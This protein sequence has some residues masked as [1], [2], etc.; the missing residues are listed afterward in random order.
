MSVIA[1]FS[2]LN[3]ID[4]AHKP[5]W[6]AVGDNCCCYCEDD[7][8]AIN[9]VAGTIP[10]GLFRS[11]RYGGGIYM[12]VGNNVAAISTDGKVFSSIAIPPGNWS[13]CVYMEHI[14][15]WVVV[16]GLWPT[17]TSSAYVTS[18]NNGATWVS[19]T[20]PR[21]QPWLGLDYGEGI[22]VAVCRTGS[23]NNIHR[24]TDGVSWTSTSYQNARFWVNVR[25]LH[26]TAGASV[27]RWV[28]TG[29]SGVGRVFITTDAVNFSWSI[30][31]TST[32][33][34]YVSHGYVEGISND[35]VVRSF[36]GGSSNQANYILSDSFGSPTSIAIGQ[37]STWMDLWF[38]HDSQNILNR[39]W[40]AVSSNGTKRIAT[41]SNTGSGFTMR[42]DATIDAMSLMSVVYG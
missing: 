10:S 38:K 8:Q 1:P 13:K 7:G 31:P 33:P 28:G 4:S 18:D 23:G 21:T 3:R 25:Y 19:R 30:L 2:F 11:V 5:K 35:Y 39:T 27:G 9:W 42:G 29:E 34:V 37:S 22:C 26:P 36:G 16:A 40:C 24:T 41:L 32:N 14:S 20:M 6:V 17:G 15:R 12:A